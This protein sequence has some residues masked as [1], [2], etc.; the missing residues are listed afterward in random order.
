M[1]IRA[2]ALTL[3]ALSWR[4]RR[5]RCRHRLRA[6]SLVSRRGTCLNAARSFF[7]EPPPPLPLLLLGAAW[8]L[9]PRFFLSFVWGK[10]GPFGDTATTHAQVNRRHYQMPQLPPPPLFPLPLLRIKLHL[11]NVNDEALC[12]FVA[13][14]L[15][16]I[17]DFDG[18]VVGY[19]ANRIYGCWMLPQLALTRGERETESARS[20]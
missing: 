11:Q 1:H 14:S 20:N 3:L 13:C 12:S 2:V 15:A 8:G 10:C 16:T 19:E 18:A 7:R 17:F 9:S 4:R 5:C 6:C